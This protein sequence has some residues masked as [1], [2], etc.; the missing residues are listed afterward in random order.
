MRARLRIALGDMDALD[1]ARCISRAQSS[2]D[3]GSA[4][5]S[6]EL[7][8]MSI[9]ACL[10]IQDT[11]PGLAPQQLTAVTPPGRRRRKSSKLS[12]SA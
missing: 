2:R 6:F 3:C 12:R 8:A 7:R 11:M 5:S 4:T 9:S 10:T 1:P